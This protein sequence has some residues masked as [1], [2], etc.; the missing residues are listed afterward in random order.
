MIDVISFNPQHLKHLKVQKAQLATTHFFNEPEYLDLLTMGPCYTGIY[1]GEIV[2]CAGIFPMTDYIG[3]AWAVVSERAGPAMIPLSRK[4]LPFL[5][6]TLYARVDTPVCR[7]FKNGHRWCKLLGFTNETPDVGMR[8]YGFDG[9]TYDLYAMYPRELNHG[10]T[11]P[12]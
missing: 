9:E 1:K 5:K 8:W 10:I 2:I 12:V 7:S 11:Q 6:R 4:I 3:R